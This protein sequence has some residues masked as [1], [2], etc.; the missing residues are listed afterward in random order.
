MKYNL[1]A[2]K[3]YINKNSFDD[4]AKAM[5]SRYID[6]R[7][8]NRK[9]R[10]PI[11]SLQ[12][13]TRLYQREDECDVWTEYGFF[14]VEDMTDEE[15]Q[16]AIDEMRIEINSPYDCTGKVFTMW[17]S[18]HKNPCGLLSVIHRKGLDV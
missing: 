6:K 16:E 9:E 4:T 5:V 15:I 7:T 1:Q 17:I 18:W 13:D 10:K 11:L 12:D 3:R 8:Y 2:I 14:N